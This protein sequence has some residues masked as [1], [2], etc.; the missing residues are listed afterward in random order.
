MLECMQRIL[1]FHTRLDFTRFLVKKYKNDNHLFSSEISV[2][3]Q[4]DI[5]THDKM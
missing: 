4:Y 5:N 3:A 2:T 1:L